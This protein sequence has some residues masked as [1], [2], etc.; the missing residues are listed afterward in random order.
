MSLL[1]RGAR[2][3]F[4]F[5]VL[6]IAFLVAVDPTVAELVSEGGDF[7]PDTLTRDT[8][9]GLRW[10]DVT[11]STNRSYSQILAELEPGGLF[12]GYRLGT[13][14][15]VDALWEHAGINRGNGG[16]LPENYD[17]MVALAA[18]V[19]QT[20][21][22]GN[23]GTGCTF[24]ET[25]GWVDSGDP[26]PE[27]VSAANIRWFDNSAPLTTSPT[28]PQ[29]PIGSALFSAHSD[30][31]SALRGAWLIEVPEPSASLGATTAFAVVAA[32]ASRR[33]RVGAQRG[34]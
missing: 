24:F 28:Y 3:A 33:G 23:C 26:V 10:L 4:G 19:G 25:K 15:E 11:L 16:W 7:G 29:A 22:E 30:A 32:L 31:A 34:K 6:L 14:N 12:E 2:T 1:R 13:G 27:F 9:S 21:S 8:E 20:S 17:P 5:A 18:L